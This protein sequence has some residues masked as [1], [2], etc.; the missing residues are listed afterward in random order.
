MNRQELL[1]RWVLGYVEPEMF[2]YPLKARTDK[3]PLIYEIQVDSIYNVT[4]VGQVYFSTQFR[5]GATYDVQ[6]CSVLHNLRTGVDYNIKVTKQGFPN[7]FTDEMRCIG[8]K[9]LY[10]PARKEYDLISENFIFNDDMSI[11]VDWGDGTSTTYTLEDLS[12]GDSNVIIHGNEGYEDLVCKC[13]S[14]KNK[15]FKHQYKETGN[16]IIQV[17][18]NLPRYS[19]SF[20][21]TRDTCKITK[22]I[23]WGDNNILSTNQMFYMCKDITEMPLVYSHFERTV[24]TQ[25]MFNYSDLSWNVIHDDLMKYF[26]NTYSCYNMFNYSSVEYVPA[27]FLQHNKKVEDISSLFSYSPITYIGDFAF[28]NLPNLINANNCA[29]AKT[30]YSRFGYGTLTKI[31]N[32][33]FEN[34]IKL[35][36]AFYFGETSN[37]RDYDGYTEIGD[38]IFKNCKSLKTFSNTWD[39]NY[40]LVKV[41]KGIFEGCENLEDVSYNFQ[42]CGSLKTIGDDIFKGCKKLHNMHRL[43]SGCQM[44]E[45]YPKD[46]FCDVEYSGYDIDMSDCFNTFNTFFDIDGKC[47][48]EHANFWATKYNVIG[49]YTIEDYPI[50]KMVGNIFSYRL[51]NDLIANDKR[52]Y[53]ICDEYSL[54]GYFRTLEMRGDD[55]QYIYQSRNGGH[56]Q[57]LWNYSDAINPK[58]SEVSDWYNYNSIFFHMTGADAASSNT[59]YINNF[60][61][62]ADIPKP[63]NETT[64]ANNKWIHY[65]IQ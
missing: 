10:N 64:D 13:T 59:S 37:T 3:L 26:P 45:A 18:G 21:D 36:S 33:I 57:D 65:S 56:A 34:D 62:Y 53:G 29:D 43:F 8:G 41:G 58:E 63:L 47:S 40:D 44:L 24:D 60:D 35:E 32:S 61:N 46:I 38:Y 28:A 48:M 55:I 9:T 25:G 5:I 12:N 30:A 17:R 52:V 22:I 31:G 2:Y 54:G 4:K 6:V 14:L 1:K 7:Y 16:Y 49:N 20:N 27:Y 23:Q 42:F 39:E 51:L 19:M 11:E 15:T 50:T